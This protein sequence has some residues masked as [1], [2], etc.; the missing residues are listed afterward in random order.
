[1]ILLDTHVVI[2]LSFEPRPLS[3][4]ANQAIREA[5]ARYEPLAIS[6]VTLYE[7][8]NATARGRIGTILSLD[9][10]LKETATRFSV[11]P[12]NEEIAARAVTLPADYPGDPMDRIIGA[13][14]LVEGL[15]LITADQAIRRCAAVSTIW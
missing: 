8:A 2:W 5:L 13:T 9:D 3:L 11:R 14:A 15:Q 7:L 4:S 6:A 12:I 1:M 10:L